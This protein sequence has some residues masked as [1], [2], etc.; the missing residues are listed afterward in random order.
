VTSPYHRS[1][2][3]WQILGR[4]AAPHD[5]GMMRHGMILRRTTQLYFVTAA[6]P[7]AYHGSGHPLSNDR[8]R[9]RIIGKEEGDHH[10]PYGAAAISGREA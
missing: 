4:G 3:P 9:R 2:L 5:N 1:P 7:R 10:E 6:K 8:T